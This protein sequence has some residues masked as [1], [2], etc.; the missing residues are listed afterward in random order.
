MHLHRQ[1]CPPRALAPS[2]FFSFD[3][4]ATTRSGA[5]A[6]QQEQQSTYA[7]GRATTL[8]AD[9]LLVDNDEVDGTN[10]GEELNADADEE[11]KNS[12]T[13]MVGANFIVEDVTGK[14][15]TS[16][17]KEDG[18]RHAVQTLRP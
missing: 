14:V 17:L 5:R 7:M 12:E 15:A 10:A 9:A 3:L 2:F 13:A 11:A 16:R 18:G 6:Q 1:V 8:D 4:T